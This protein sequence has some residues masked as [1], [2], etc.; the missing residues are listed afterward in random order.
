MRRGRHHDFYVPRRV[1]WP[2]RNPFVRERPTPR[3]RKG[4]LR[5]EHSPTPRIMEAPMQKVVRSTRDCQRLPRAVVALSMKGER[6]LATGYRAG[7]TH[8]HPAILRIEHL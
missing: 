7:S 1:L 3:V 8:C 6:R 5:E 2:A 4:L